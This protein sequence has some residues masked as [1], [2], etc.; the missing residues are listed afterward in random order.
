M[1]ILPH[2]TP[3]PSTTN[4]QPLS[5]QI[6]PFQHP[7]FTAPARSL[8]SDWNGF[9]PP[10]HLWRGA[11]AWS[12]QVPKTP[13]F[14][15]PILDSSPCPQHLLEAATGR[16]GPHS[17]AGLHVPGWGG[18]SALTSSSQPRGWTELDRV[19]GALSPSP[20]LTALRFPRS[21]CVGGLWPLPAQPLAVMLSPPG[22]PAEPGGEQLV[23]RGPGFSGLL[24][25]ARQDIV[26]FNAETSTPQASSGTSFRS[27]P[28]EPSAQIAPRP[29]EARSQVMGGWGKVGERGSSRQ[30]APP[31][32]FLCNAG[33]ITEEP[34][35][36]P[37]PSGFSAFESRGSGGTCSRKLFLPP[38]PV[39]H[40]ADSPGPPVISLRQL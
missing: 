9:L 8:A 37:Q 13:D 33:V 23:H 27:R 39:P 4:P 17:R 7:Q 38:A 19:K 28:P 3:L 29:R 31:V 2:P 6:Q 36:V 10:H 25:P 18:T 34:R 30:E 21:A 11:G 15:F 26:T 12:H 5:P 24:L 40:P 1:S 32:L 35:E 22:P 20:G 16:G 14:F